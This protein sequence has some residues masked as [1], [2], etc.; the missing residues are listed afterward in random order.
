[1]TRLLIGYDGADGAITATGTLFPTA[2]LRATPKVLT[3]LGAW[4]QLQAVVVHAWSSPVRH[5]LRGD[6]LARSGVE[7]FE[8]YV[9]TIYAE[10]AHEPAE[11]VAEYARG[12]GLIASAVAS[13]SGQGGWRTLLAA[14]RE[15]GTAAILVGSRG[16]G[17]IASTVLG[18]VASGLVNAAGLPVLVVPSNVSGDRRCSLRGCSPTSARPGAWSRANTRR[19]FC[20]RRR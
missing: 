2:G 10:A 4:R 16:R 14:A 17:A 11:D 18:S 15:S 6:A 5:T 13:E 3:G 1:V 12:L 20:S 19:R 8:D 7:T 9:D